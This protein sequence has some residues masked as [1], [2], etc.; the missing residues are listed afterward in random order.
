MKKIFQYKNLHEKLKSTSDSEKRPVSLYWTVPLRHWCSISVTYKL[1]IP[2][3]QVVPSFS[4]IS[5]VSIKPGIILAGSYILTTLPCAC[6]RRMPSV[7]FLNRITLVHLHGGSITFSMI[8]LS[9][10]PTRSYPRR[11]W[12]HRL[13]LIVISAMCS[14]FFSTLYAEFL[15]ISNLSKLCSLFL[16]FNSISPFASQIDCGLHEALRSQGKGKVTPQVWCI[17]TKYVTEFRRTLWCRSHML[18]LI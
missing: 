15:T 4:C 14:P 1:Q 12:L 10:S 6:L 11:N 8:G 2:P 7:Y 3:L 18:I 17:L 5:P 16:L 13:H 9:S